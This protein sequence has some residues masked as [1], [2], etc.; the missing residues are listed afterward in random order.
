[1]LN[2]WLPPSGRTGAQHKQPGNSKSLGAVDTIAFRMTGMVAVTLSART[3][4]RFKGSIQRRG[5]VCGGRERRAQRRYRTRRHS[6]VAARLCITRPLAAMR[7]PREKHQRRWAG[8]G[9]IALI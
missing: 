1:V 5:A 7:R 6:L 4:R 3:P 2:F 9:A 8:F